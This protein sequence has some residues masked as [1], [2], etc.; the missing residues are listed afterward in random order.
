M[1]LTKMFNFNK[2]IIVTITTIIIW[3]ILFQ[4]GRWLVI[5]P[6]YSVSPQEWMKCPLNG[7]VI[8]KFSVYL[9]GSLLYH[10]LYLVLYNLIL[11][12][13]LGIVLSRII[14]KNGKN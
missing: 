4:L 7:V 2:L 13:V 9:F 11:P 14:A 5:V 12:I 6:C 10:R 1:N 8:S 3:F